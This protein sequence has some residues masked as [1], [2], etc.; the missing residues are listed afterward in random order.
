MTAEEMKDLKIE[1]RARKIVKRKLEV[2]IRSLMPKISQQVA[3]REARKQQLTEYRNYNDLQDAY[4]WGIITEEEF[5]RLA[6]ALE[7]GTEAIDKEVTAEEIAKDVLTGW[8]RRTSGDISSLEFEMLPEK[9]QIEILEQ[10][11]EIA[12]RRQERRA[13]NET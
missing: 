3:A 7:T 5:D 13:N 11:Y 2:A 6:A 4:G 12:K 8:L 9:K 10:N 1:L